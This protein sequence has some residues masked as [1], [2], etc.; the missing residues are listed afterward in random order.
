MGDKRPPWADPA[1]PLEIKKWNT[2]DGSIERQS[3]MGVYEIHDGMP[4]N[5]VGRTGITGKFHFTY[6]TKLSNILFV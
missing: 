4:R 5:P 2:V 1:D 6:Q 3:H